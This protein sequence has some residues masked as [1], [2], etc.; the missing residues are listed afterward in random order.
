[1]IRFGKVVS[2]AHAIVCDGGVGTQKSATCACGRRRADVGIGP[3]T[4]PEG[5]SKT[6]NQTAS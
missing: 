2:D 1:M 6:R 3:Y 4:F 5:L